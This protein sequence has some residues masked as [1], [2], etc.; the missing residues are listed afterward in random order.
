VR[1]ALLHSFAKYCRTTG[2]SI[3]VRANFF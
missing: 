2:Q 1:T 3:G